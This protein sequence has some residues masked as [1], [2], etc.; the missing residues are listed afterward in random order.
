MPAYPLPTLAAVVT[1][2]GISAPQYSDIY[3]SLQA[4]F[5][6]IF[7]ADAYVAPDSQ[8]GQLLAII[9]SAINDA[10]TMAIAVY[11]SFSPTYAQGAALSSN[12]K[13]NGLRRQVPTFSTA[14][15]DVIGVVGT[16]IL[17]GVARDE[18]GALWN[19]PAS[20][21]I[22][23]AGVISVTV[24]AQEVGAI[25]AP[26]GSINA[27]ST[28]TLGW[29][30]FTST[31][32]A[33]P[34]APVESDAALRQRQ[35]ASTGQSAETPLGSVYG[36]VANL[37]GVTA[38][39]VYENTGSA[40]DSDGIPGHSISV[41]V[42][43][44][45]AEEIATAIGQKKTPG[46]GTYGTT[47]HAYTDPVTGIVYTIHF[48]APT[49]KAIKIHLT[50]HALAGFVTATEAEIATVVAAYVNSLGIGTDVQFTRLYAPAYLNGA[51]DN[52]T[53]EVTGMT[54][55]IGVGTP[56]TA[57]LVIA[58]NE[59]ATCDAAADVSFTVT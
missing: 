41:V 56:G 24:T 12:V 33:V 53:Y 4:S 25:P 14:V 11:N 38:L 34:G 21:T 5:Q 32:D 57:D 35:A 1:S 6:G 16:A 8:D 2:A 18:N 44:G 36:A 54:I 17:N 50:L 45:D 48:Y 59:L 49:L 58:F 15:G 47:S 23:D 7:G 37:L 46:A 3:A 29:Q 28:P 22:P 55:A 13:I 20:V 26:S 30:S 10:N 39:R 43:G 40:T 19:L 31:S 51:S 52:V 42:A 9:A 27:I